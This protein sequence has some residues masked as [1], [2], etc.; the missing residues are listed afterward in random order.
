[1]TQQ[2]NTGRR[3]PQKEVDTPTGIHIGGGYYDEIEFVGEVEKG[4]NMLTVIRARKGQN[5]T[6]RI[7]DWWQTNEGNWA[8]SKN[9]GI[10]LPLDDSTLAEII[11]KG[12]AD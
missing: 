1:M 11:A 9:A 6:L 12:F 8:P 5:W 10:S 3:T 7:Q 4:K 2:S